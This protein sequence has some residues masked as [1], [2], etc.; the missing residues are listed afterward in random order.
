MVHQRTRLYRYWLPPILWAAVIFAA[1]GNAFAAANTAPVLAS[2][3]NAFLGRA[4]TPSQFETIHFLVRKAAHLT[5]Y[6]IFGALLFRAIRAGREGWNWRWAV[7]AIA[8]AALYA[9]SDEWHQSFVP[10]RTPSVIDVLI[11]TTGATLAQVLFFR[12]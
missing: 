6:G 10:S 8:I 2:I 4:P 1:S 12:T 7:W 9:A 5:E 3:L 11:D